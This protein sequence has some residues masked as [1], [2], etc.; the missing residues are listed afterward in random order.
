MLKKTLVLLVVLS[1]PAFLFLNIWQVFSFQQL[2]R[3]VSELEFQQKEWFEENK[4]KVI[5]IEY[6]S[7]PRRLEQIAREELEL[8]KMDPDRIIRVIIPESRSS[9]D[10]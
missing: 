2:E 8:E 10:G 4:R 1:V 3:E 7:S 5:G 9:I 6:L